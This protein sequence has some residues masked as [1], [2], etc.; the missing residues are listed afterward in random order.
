MDK[1]EPI[2]KHRFWI[3]L[4]LVAPLTIFGYYSANAALKEATE[5]RE[6][7]IDALFNKVPSGSEPTP[8]WTQGMS[9][10]NSHFE[11]DVNTE[12]VG[13]Y[14]RQQARMTW[15]ASMQKYLPAKYRD[16]FVNEAGV[17]YANL[18]ADLIRDLHGRIEP[19]T[20]SPQGKISGSG[21]VLFEEKLIPRA[22]FAGRLSIPSEMIWDAQEDIWYLELLFDAIRNVNQ[23]AENAAKSA[24]RAVLKVELWGGN[25][26]SSVKASAGGGQSLGGGMGEPSAEMAMGMGMEMRGGMG[27]M[28]GGGR[29]V[30]VSFNPEEEFGTGGQPLASLGGP[31]RMMGGPMGMSMPEGMG[32]MPEEGGTG[33][34]KTPTKLLRYVKESEASPYR[35]R[36]FYLSVLIDQRKIADFLIELTNSDWPIRIGRFHVGPNPHASKTRSTYGPMS[37][38]AGGEGSFGAEVEAQMEMMQAAMGGNSFEGGMDEMEGGFG[39]PTLTLTGPAVD[40]LQHHD[41]VQLD[42][43]GYITFYKSPAEDVLAAVKQASENASGTAAPAVQPVAPADDSTAAD[44][45]STSDPTSPATPSEESGESQSPS[46]DDPAVPVPG[47][48]DPTGASDAAE[49]PPTTPDAGSAPG[50][51]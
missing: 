1:L 12:I 24:V 36:G 8:R 48:I 21:K 41:L 30:D 47:A 9:Q 19:V 39:P 35:E 16:P 44:G 2:L 27:G 15:P 29:S 5:K 26:E 18:Y 31:R 38:L 49:A 14:E 45:A 28:M 20:I 17:V 7:E 43:V 46:A 34:A 23:P 40:L 22:T 4:G 37:P 42:L 50:T 6:G 51:P 33:V 11:Q 13:I 32:A 10:I 25:G 3:L